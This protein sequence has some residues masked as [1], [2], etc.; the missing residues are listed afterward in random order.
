MIEWHSRRTLVIPGLRIKAKEKVKAVIS[1]PEVR[2]NVSQPFIVKIMQYA[3]GRHVGG[4]QLIKRHPDWKPEP[5]PQ[6]YNLWIRVLNGHSLRAIPEAQVKIFTWDNKKGGFVPEAD[7]HTDEMGIVEVSGLPCSDKKLLI[8]EHSLWQTKI[9]RFRP[10]PGQKVKQTFK[11]WQSKQ[12]LSPYQWRAQDTL[13]AIATLTGSQ[14][15]TILKM[16]SLR[17][18]SELKPAKTIEIP[19]FEPVYH[20]EARDTL[21]HLVE[22]FC[23]NKVEELVAANDLSKP[24]QLYQDQEL[25]LPGW[26]FFQAGPVELFEKLDEQFGIP[27]GWSRPAQRTLHDDPTHAYEHEVVAVPTQEFVRDHKLRRLY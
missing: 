11:L 12:I 2:I 26:R 18:A 24:Y 23:Y 20:V 25:S 5:I 4:V 9:W 6:K 19:C 27:R 7:W 1:V 21:E 10:L 8:I 22:Y 13:K 14:Q 16:N 17:S 15:A 3:D